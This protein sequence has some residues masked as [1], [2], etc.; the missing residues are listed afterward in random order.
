MRAT[1]EASGSQRMENCGDVDGHA[2]NVFLDG[3]LASDFFYSLAV[4]C[5]ASGEAK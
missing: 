1:N 5:D 4:L 3:N 2:C